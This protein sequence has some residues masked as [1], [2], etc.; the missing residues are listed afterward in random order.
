MANLA[1]ASM[2]TAS[3]AARGPST[4]N[5]APGNAMKVG[6][7]ARLG[8]NSCTHDNRVYGDS[9]I[10]LLKAKRVSNWAPRNV[11]SEVTLVEP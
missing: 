7:I 8:L 3:L 9:A 5:A 1:P 4:V 2:R 10:P 11:G 6:L